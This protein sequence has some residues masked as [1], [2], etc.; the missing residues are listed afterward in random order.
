MASWVVDWRVPCDVPNVAS[1]YRELSSKQGTPRVAAA[2]FIPG[3]KRMIARREG[4]VLILRGIIVNLLWPESIKEMGPQ[5]CGIDCVCVFLGV[6]EP[7]RLSPFCD[8]WKLVGRHDAPELLNGE[9]V[10]D[11]DWSTVES[12]IPVPPLQDFRIY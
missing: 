7:Y 10:S 4:D 11:L 2:G 3:C 9:A 8:G 5:D 1:L 12:E 6:G